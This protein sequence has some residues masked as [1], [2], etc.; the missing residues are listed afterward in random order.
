MSLGIWDACSFAA[1]HRAGTLDG[2]SAERHPVGARILAPADRMFRVAC[3]RP[4]L[5]QAVRNAVLRHVVRYPA[6]QRRIAPQLLEI[7]Y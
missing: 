2:Y 1:R 6:I 5:G 3:L 7:D 4:G